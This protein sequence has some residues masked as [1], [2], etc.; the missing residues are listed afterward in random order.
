MH[1]E[2]LQNS[3]VFQCGTGKFRTNRSLWNKEKYDG[4]DH[5]LQTH[6]YYT[7]M[8]IKANLDGF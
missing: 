1:A 6:I 2:L 5:T 8:K 7:H 4:E 3:S